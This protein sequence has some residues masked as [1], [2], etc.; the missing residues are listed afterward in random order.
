MNQKT[1]TLGFDKIYVINL[2]RR[3]DRKKQLLIDFPNLNFTFIEAIDGKE[4][5]MSQLSSDNLINSSFFDPN[6]MITMGVFACALSHKKAWDQAI[7][8]GVEN[9]LFLEDD[10]HSTTPLLSDSALSPLYQNILNECKESDY[11]LIHLGKKTITQDC[12]NLNPPLGF[13]VKEVI[14]SYVDHNNIKTSIL[15]I[16]F[17]AKEDTTVYIIAAG[18]PISFKNNSF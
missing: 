17:P 16:S 8:D 3:L 13:I 9:A 12:L 7:E 10:V 5:T 4:I 18:S 11:D 6:G 2:K 15:S 1:S 14:G